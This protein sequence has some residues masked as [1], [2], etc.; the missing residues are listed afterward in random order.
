MHSAPRV[1]GISTSANVEAAMLHNA[2]G[3]AVAAAGQALDALLT[4]VE[5]VLAQARCSLAEVQLIAVCSGPGSFTGLRIGV[6]FARSL[7]QARDLPIVGISAYDVMEQ[8]VAH[9]PLVAVAKG[10]TGFYYMRV[11]RTPEAAPEF[12]SGDA[13]GIAQLVGRLEDE[14]GTTASVVGTDFS[15]LAAGERARRVALLGRQAYAAGAPATWRDLA[16]DYGQRPNAVINW[17]E[18]AAASRQ[19]QPFQRRESPKR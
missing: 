1:L 10:K 15:A 2:A 12:S 13:G 8:G 5:D 18:R 16:I 6:A 19:G 11:R 14:S 9:H 3:A 17:E 7:A 4:S